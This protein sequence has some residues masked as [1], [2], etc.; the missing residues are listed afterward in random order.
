MLNTI[1]MMTML[2]SVSC[3]F[4]DNI[5]V[6]VFRVKVCVTKHR[7]TLCDHSSTQHQHAAAAYVLN[8][9]REYILADS[10]GP[11]RPTPSPT[12]CTVTE[13]GLG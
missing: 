3:T 2:M 11:D 8:E 9:A 6:M 5:E 10:P 1:Y 12:Q 13:A 7:K 4:H